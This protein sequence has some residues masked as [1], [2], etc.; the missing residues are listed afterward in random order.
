MKM[1]VT[2]HLPFWEVLFQ[3]LT[4]KLAAILDK[5]EN[6]LSQAQQ[7][8]HACRDAMNLL[9]E[10]VIQTGFPCDTEEIFFFKEIKPK[11]YSLL[12]FYQHVYC[13]ETSRP[14]GNEEDIKIFY[15]SQLDRVQHFFI[16]N[17]FFYQYH[18]C[19][20]TL[21]DDKLFLRN[22]QGASLSFCIDDINAHPLFST[23]IDYIFSRIIANELLAG[24]LQ[25]ALSPKEIEN[26]EVKF[27][28]R[29][30]N[31]THH[32]S[33]FVEFVYSAKA[34]GLFNNGSATLKE[35]FDYLQFVFKIKVPH[36]TTVF[37]EILRRKKG[38]YTQFLDSLR[39]GYLQYIDELQGDG[40]G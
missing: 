23:G 38:G 4:D 35:I 9:Q 13:L 12:L 5:P 19:R 24:Y 39:K 33:A 6:S 14:I 3:E 2:K 32:K 40:Q 11:F 1:E 16:D 29:P 28:V 21:F 26:E 7:S 22:K 30:L 8:L 15:R 31:W 10:H 37:Q 20:E 34:N 17:K 36:Y 27:K 25:K 18:R